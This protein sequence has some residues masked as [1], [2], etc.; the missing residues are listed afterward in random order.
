VVVVHAFNLST[1]EVEEGGSLVSSKH[2]WST[3]RVQT[4]RTTY[5]YLVWWF[6]HV[7]PIG[8]GTVE[9]FGLLEEVSHYGSELWSSAQCR[10]VI[11]LLAAVR[12]RCVTL[13]SSWAMPAS[14]LPCSYLDDNGL[15]LWTC[16][17]PQWNVDIIR[18]AL[19]MVSVHSSK[20][21]TKTPCLEKAKANKQNN[22]DTHGGLQH[23]YTYNPNTGQISDT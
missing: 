6:E 2:V 19:V 5:W 3:S 23:L 1:L 13:S 20:T 9:R 8:S 16:S 21:L 11:F 4:A 12:W 10:R 7:C 15:N 17:Q 14:T 22:K 18:E